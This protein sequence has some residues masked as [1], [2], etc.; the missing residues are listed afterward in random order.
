MV[1]VNETWHC[2]QVFQQKKCKKGRCQETRSIRTGNFFEN[3]K[4][5]LTQITCLILMW[6]WDSFHVSIRETLKIS[7]STVT[8]W[9]DRC[10]QVVKSKIE[11]NQTMLGGNGLTVEVYMKN[12]CERTT[13]HRPITDLWII[14]GVQ[15]NSPN[16]FT[17]F[18]P[19]SNDR[20][21]I[22]SV[23]QTFVLPKTTIITNS[24][25]VYADIKHIP[26]MDFMHKTLDIQRG[27]VC[28][29]DKNIHL[30]NVKSFWSGLKNSIEKVAEMPTSIPALWRNIVLK[31]CV[32]SPEKICSMT[33]L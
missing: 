6:C 2:R 8:F 27:Y 31:E 16:V 30:N 13:Y 5:S 10:R 28:P 14:F 17:E 20:D 24:S 33:F 25:V 11:S 15:R 3:S 29:N 22:L 21:T 4:L 32:V 23:I 19:K 7:D 9:T 12:L 1:L 26:G 18:I